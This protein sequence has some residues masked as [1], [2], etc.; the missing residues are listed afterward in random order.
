[1]LH[2]KSPAMNLPGFPKHIE[3]L[4][5]ADSVEKVGLPKLLEYWWVKT[6]FLHAATWNPSQAASAEGKD[7]NLRRVPFSHGNQAGLFQHNRPIS[8]CRHPQL[9]GLG[10]R[11]IIIESGMEWGC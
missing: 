6:P 11:A 7:F 3:G 10:W 4:L 9:C 8:A 1:M 2:S 5:L